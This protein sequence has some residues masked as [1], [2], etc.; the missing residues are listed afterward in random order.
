MF[1]NSVKNRCIS[2]LMQ[3]LAGVGSRKKSEIANASV[4]RRF[5]VA[6]SVVRSARKDGGCRSW[7]RRDATK[8]AR[9][10]AASPSRNAR[11]SLRSGNWR[12]FDSSRNSLPES[13][14]PAYILLLYV[15]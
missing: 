2:P 7:R 9:C 3:S 11:F 1:V 13:R 5:V 12:R 6:R 15:M 8:S 14:S 10:S 4:R